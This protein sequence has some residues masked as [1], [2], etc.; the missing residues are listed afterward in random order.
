[1]KRLNLSAS[2]Y[3]GGGG[4]GGGGGVEEA[5][6]NSKLKVFVIC[7]PMTQDKR[8]GHCCQPLRVWGKE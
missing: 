3:V 5:R 1:M 6:N 7:T 4:G 2:L 8:A